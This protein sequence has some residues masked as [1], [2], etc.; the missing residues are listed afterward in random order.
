MIFKLSDTNYL[1]PLSNDTRMFKV[2]TP[3]T[4][5]REGIL[6]D[7]LEDGNIPLEDAVEIRTTNLLNNLRETNADLFVNS[8]EEYSASFPKKFIELSIASSFMFMF[9]EDYLAFFRCY[10]NVSMKELELLYKIESNE[11]KEALLELYNINHD[12]NYTGITTYDVRDRRANK[13]SIFLYS[14]NVLELLVKLKVL[15]LNGENVYHQFQ[16]TFPNGKVRILDEPN[17]VIMSPLKIMNTNLTKI[18]GNINPECQFAY[19]K[20][21]SVLHNALPHKNHRYIFKADIEDFFPSCK[22]ELVAKYLKVIFKEC[23]NYEEHLEYF[24]NQILVSDALCLGNP[25]SPVLANTIIAKPAKFIYNMCNQCDMTFTQYCDDLTFS[26]DRPIAKDFIVNIFNTA[27][28]R[29]HLNEYFHL[30]IRKLV[31]QV[32]QYRNVTGV[33]FDHTDNNNPTPRR[34]IYRQLRVSIHK[35]SLG[36]NVNVNKIKGQIAYMAMLGKGKR[37]LNYIEE[38][39]PHLKDRLIGPGLLQKIQNEGIEN[40]EVNIELPF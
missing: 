20:K 31:G 14:S 7:I 2:I 22:R 32:G 40:N 38:K 36:E 35:L 8:I 16:K 33:A 28:E 21:K 25:I 24:L 23:I 19:K 6:G 29:Y 26:S 37:V 10:D 39:F 17:A 30:K 11:H 12:E 27:Y 18:Y 9:V 13:Q 3:E 1:V 4:A 34:G 15:E 5:T